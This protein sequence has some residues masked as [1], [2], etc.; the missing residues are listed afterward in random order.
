MNGLIFQI[1]KILRI[2]NINLLRRPT[3]YYDIDSCLR[4]LFMFKQNK[5]LFPGVFNFLYFTL[6][7][8]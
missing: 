2:N 6:G 7:L 3:Y 5:Y 4:R 8:H 1:V